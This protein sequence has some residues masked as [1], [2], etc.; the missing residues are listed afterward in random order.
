MGA[1]A[2]TLNKQGF[3]PRPPSEERSDLLYLA[4]WGANLVSIHAPSEE[5]S[6][7]DSDSHPACS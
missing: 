1:S 4:S 5:R 2:I 6:D 3:N 7:S